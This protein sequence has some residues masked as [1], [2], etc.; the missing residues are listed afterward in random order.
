VAF[1]QTPLLWLQLMS[2]YKISWTVAPDPAY[3]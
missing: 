2:R 3:R 1:E